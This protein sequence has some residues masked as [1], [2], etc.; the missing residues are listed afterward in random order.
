MNF[1]YP[2]IFYFLLLLLLPILV[3]LF[4]LRRFKTEYFTNVKFLKELSLQTRKSSKIKK[5][6]LLATR[7]LLLSCLIFAFAQ[8]FLKSKVSKNTSNE[9]FIVLDNSFSMQAKGKKGE[10]LKRAVQDLLENVPENQQ[11]S[12]VTNTENYWNTDIKSIQNELQNLQ[13]SASPF[14]FDNLMAKINAYK[15]AFNKDIIV[16]TDAIDLKESQLKSIDKNDNAYFI[17][18]KSVQENNVSVDSV[19]INRNSEEFYEIGIKLKLFGDK[20]SNFPVALYNFD[21][22]IA[23]T[24]LSF[25]KNDK[26]INFSLPKEDFHGYVSIDD[27]SLFYDNKLYF[28]LSKPKKTSVIA[29][30]DF[31]K[32]DFLNRIYTNDE[33]VFQ[34]FEL[35]ALDYNLLDK[36]DAIILNE[37]INIPQA[38]QTTLNDFVSKGGNLIF[39]PSAT[40][41][42]ENTND[43]LKKFGNLKFTAIENSDK[44]VTKIHFSN[45]LFSTVFEKKI[46]NFQYPSTKIS[47]S[48]T[49]NFAPILSYA[50]QNSFLLSIPQPISSIFIFTAPINKID[51]NFQ[52]SPLIV[53]IFYKMSQN[54]VITG[55]NAMIIGQNNPFFVDVL[56]KKDEI[57]SVKKSKKLKENFIPIQQILNNKV[58]LSFGDN[59]QLAGNYEIYNRNTALKNIS[60]NYNRIESN[61]TQTNENLLSDYKIVSNISAILDKINTDRTDSQIWKIFIIF[62]LMFLIVEIF[63]QKFIK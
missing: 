56:L 47:Y 49:G 41:S 13:Y 28:S 20:K 60:F 29:I 50:N 6:L 9:L 52:N 59:P 62:A 4:Q 8:P 30:G 40:C 23:K 38:L 12:L 51:S 26:I 55:V 44:L 34:N 15:S 22:L 37:L 35:A 27:N 18:P 7:L 1:K 3:H 45:P 10:L 63:I 58:K 43:F 48:T 16:I 32:S 2:E 57:L 11:F 21:K 25:D 31:Q 61:M 54:A 42:L 19:F 39:I 53:P 36:Q 46:D 5:L 24:I 14:V 33:F 17:F